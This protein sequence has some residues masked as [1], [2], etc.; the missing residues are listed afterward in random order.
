MSKKR[1]KSE[2]FSDSIDELPI[3]D[4]TSIEEIPA[5]TVPDIEKVKKEP[6]GRIVDFTQAFRIYK[7]NN[8]KSESW[9]L[10]SVK[11]F[12]CKKLGKNAEIQDWFKV[13]DNY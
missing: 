2:E 8:K 6:C 7:K 11:V 3:S 5:V 10:E 4:A 12:S 1:N 13:F 9:D